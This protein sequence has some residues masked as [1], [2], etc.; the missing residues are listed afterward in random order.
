MV[1]AGVSRDASV[2]CVAPGQAPN[3]LESL[4]RAPQ[5]G[6]GVVANASLLPEGRVGVRAGPESPTTS[7]IGNS[8]ASTAPSGAATS[9]QLLP[10]RTWRA[11]AVARACFGPTA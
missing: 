2:A 7:T 3:R 10:R 5:V 1:V 8:T 11:R 4:S 6:A 9:R